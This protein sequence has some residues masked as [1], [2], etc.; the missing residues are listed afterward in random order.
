MLSEPERIWGASL[1]AHPM[2][3]LRMSLLTPS[4]CPPSPARPPALPPPDCAVYIERPD[5]TE[6]FGSTAPGDSDGPV[7]QE[8]HRFLIHLPSTHRGTHPPFL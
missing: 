4:P 5:E 7:A 3:L 8:M 1:C 6:P 2:P